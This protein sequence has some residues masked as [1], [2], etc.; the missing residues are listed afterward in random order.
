M[1]KTIVFFIACFAIT[2]GTAQEIKVMPAFTGYAMPREKT[3]SDDNSVLFG[4]DGLH[5]WKDPQQQIQY[6]FYCKQA[7]ELQLQINAR[8][9]S[10]DSKL[11]IEF[12][13]KIFS[14]SISKSAD[15]KKLTI[16][17]VV[18]S[19]PGFYH[20]KLTGS[21]KG[22]I[23]ADISNLYFTGTASVEMEFNSKA[24]RNAASVHLFYTVPDSFKT[25]SF[26]NE[27]TVP[28]TYDHVYSYYMACGFKRGYFGMQVNSE[29]ERRIIFSVWDAGN[30]AV[31]RNKVNTENKVQLIAKGKDVFADGFGN[32]GTGGHSHWVYNWKPGVK[33]EFLVTALPDSAG[34]L[35][36][37]TGYFFIPELQQWKLIA[38][39]SA[40]KDGRYLD[41]LYSFN[42]DFDGT[43][44]Q[45][46][47]KALFGNQ[48]IRNENGDWKELTSAAFSI[49]ATGKAGDRIDYGAGIK[50]GKFLLWN[51]GYEPATA[52]PGDLFKRAP[53]NIKP[54]IDLYKN[55]DSAA[56]AREEHAMIL[57]AVSAGK[58]DTT[59][60][61]NGIYYKIL[62]E[63][64][65]RKVKV[66][67]TVIAYY[68]GNLFN[69]EIFDQTKSE[70]ATFPLNR[71]IKGWQMALPQCRIGG[72]IQIIIPSAL[73][74]S[75]RSRSA[76]IPPNS[77]LIFE[78]EV[79]GV[80][81]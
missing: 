4:K 78:I 44:G 47:R 7:G 38:S 5:N 81:E 27:L 10:A 67:D 71:L 48:W 9:A 22:K 68:K 50:E 28:E 6:F 49:D 31:E 45:L 23:I 15:Y 29:N 32:E 60:S 33:Y 8:N 64:T 2:C 69:G 17:T 51:G 62:K 19:K 39:F 77:I 70:P 42:E 80:K 16:G 37:Y 11:N 1:K 66:T 26:Y 54:V 72:K 73:A 34:N 76:K 58:I 55:A 24:R 3:D 12:A 13:D 25:V 41:H 79:V 21:I 20:I 52:K 61:I 14:V 18:I 74:Y 56:I 75:I 53:T 65:G 57:N 36:I 30:E 59:G 43:N 35:T 46:Q 40:P 63:G